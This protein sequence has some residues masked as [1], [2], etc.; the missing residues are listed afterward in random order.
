MSSESGSWFAQHKR[1]LSLALVLLSMAARLA[2]LKG[3]QWLLSEDIDDYLR[4][5]ENISLWGTFGSY[6]KPTAYRPPLYPLLLA[7]LYWLQSHL[8]L[9]WGWR[10]AAIACLHLVFGAGTTVLTFRLADRLGLGRWSLLA[11]VL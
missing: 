8:G 11:G 4:L 10:I 2:T 9:A 1:A 6:D 5:A 3:N 7:P